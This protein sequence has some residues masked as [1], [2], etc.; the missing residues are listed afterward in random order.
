MAF[1]PLSVEFD[2]PLLGCLS[3]TGV[4]IEPT[5]TERGTTFFH[6]KPALQTQW[7]SCEAIILDLQRRL[8]RRAGILYLHTS[9]PPAPT[10]FGYKECYISRNEATEHLKKALSAFTARLVLLSYLVLK[11]EARGLDTWTDLA[12]EPD[13]VPLAVCNVFRVSWVSDWTVPRVGAFVDIGRR[14]LPTGSSDWHQD[15]RLF[16]SKGTCVP[17]WFTFTSDEAVDPL[18]S[19]E[20]RHAY[21]SFKP[22]SRLR[23]ALADAV[24]TVFENETCDVPLNR[25]PWD[26]YYSTMS[27]SR[28]SLPTSLVVR[29]RKSISTMFTVILGTRM[30]LAITAL[31]PPSHGSVW[32]KRFKFRN[33]Q[34]CGETYD[35][36]MERQTQDSLQLISHETPDERE[37]RHSREQRNLSQPVP[38]GGVPAVY[39]WEFIPHYHSYL[40]TRV[41]P[42]HVAALW[43]STTSSS[44]VYNAVRNEYD[45]RRVAID[46]EQQITENTLPF[47]AADTVLAHA[48]PQLS[49]SPARVSLS[50]VIEDVLARP[51]T[52]KYPAVQTPTV[53][54]TLRFRYGYMGGTVTRSA[55]E[56]NT[57]P[58]EQDLLLSLCRAAGVRTTDSSLSGGI[59]SDVA[60]FIST[61]RDNVMP[62]RG[63]FDLADPVKAS[64]PQ[65]CIGVYLNT[66]SHAFCFAP[67]ES[68]SQSRDSPSSV[69]ILIPTATSVIHAHRLNIYTSRET[70]VEG[71]LSRGIQFNILQMMTPSHDDCTTCVVDTDTLVDGRPIGM[72]ILPHGMQLNYRDYAAY[73][74]KLRELLSGPLGIAALQSGGI[75][76]RLARGVRD[77]E[78]PVQEVLHSAEGVT[79]RTT[80]NGVEYRSRAVSRQD[81]FR[82]VGTYRILNGVYADK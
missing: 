1:V 21:D 5:K 56:E 33:R 23:V 38:V 39:L 9:V 49:P 76:W 51:S 14:V 25:L 43:E 71:L 77:G 15:V 73:D 61:L 52:V 35:E 62:R 24:T 55:A 57:E 19:D 8:I 10:A 46:D 53:Q 11:E 47:P 17:L 31:V 41:L 54:D 78:L 3:P 12:L 16:L 81:A 28:D 40:R 13:P 68:D 26:M 6:L 30:T 20:S 60:V 32:H 22:C 75:L 37:A 7:H 64:I 63:L 36:F 74:T 67:T 58:V 70:L 65:R 29:R 44:R 34:L 42:S 48:Q 69:C 59:A 80:M 18:T 2:G 79:C 27:L 50:S 45:V 72:G 66:T 4:V 82:L